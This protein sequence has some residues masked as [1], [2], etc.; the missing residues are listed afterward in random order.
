MQTAEPMSHTVTVEEVH[1][2]PKVY[3]LHNL[4]TLDECEQMVELSKDKLVRSTTVNP[5]TGENS[6]VDARSSYGGFFQLGENP[7]VA[8][9]ERRISALIQRPLDHGEGT[10]ILRY[11]S[12]QEYK[13]HFDFFDPTHRATP[14]II[15]N[16]GQRILSVVMYLS[17]VEEGGET[18]LPELNLSFK[19]RRG[20]AVL[21]YNLHPNGEPDRKTLHGS[22]PV[23]R[24]EKWGATKWVRERRFC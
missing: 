13:P 20:D 12:G 2:A 24:G 4:L 22:V 17:D 9:I 18:I 1:F 11:Q 10:Q 21:F 16:S 8:R 19:P 7:I 14:K 6:L 15:A 5:E 3:Y 23:I